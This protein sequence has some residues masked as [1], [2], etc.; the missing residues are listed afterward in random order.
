M[1]ASAVYRRWSFSLAQADV[2]NATAVAASSPPSTNLGKLVFV[3]S[4]EQ[5]DFRVAE[6]AA[7]LS[8][9]LL[10]APSPWGPWSPEL[11]PASSSCSLA[12]CSAFQRPTKAA[13]RPSSRS[14]I[15][16]CTG[17]K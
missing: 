1:S 6:G 9:Q 14:E 17:P 2:S 5:L 16:K 3:G 11:A 12:P 8:H 15:S 13:A 4:T 7:A 10:S